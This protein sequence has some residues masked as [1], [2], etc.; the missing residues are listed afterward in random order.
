M[1]NKNTMKN[2][3]HHRMVVDSKIYLM[4]RNRNRNTDLGKKRGIKEMVRK[5][6]NKQRNG[7]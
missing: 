3:T 1:I 2:K 6:R 7:G 4:Q 5:I